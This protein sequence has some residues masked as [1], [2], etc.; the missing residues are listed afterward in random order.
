MALKLCKSCKKEVD[1]TAKTCPH[2]GVKDPGITGGQ[3]FIG[4]LIVV[5]L[6]AVIASSCTGEETDASPSSSTTL[7]APSPTSAPEVQ[8]TPAAKSNLGMT[9]EEFRQTYN[10]LIGQVDKSWRVAE[11]DVTQG[12]VNDTFTAKLGGAAG[13]VGTVDKA[14]KKLISVMVIAGGGEGK[15]NM[16]SIAVLM[17]TAH[18]L[19]QG[20][21]KQEISDAVSTLVTAAFNGMEQADTPLQSRT[22]GNRKLSATASS[23]TG[24]MF[25][26]SSTQ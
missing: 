22:V 19:T 7:T 8:A 26:V 15:D 9:P 1:H 2:C 17:S 3:I 6:V 5:A 16:Q 4:F 20:A 25:S 21:S 10:A 18:A 23:I 13:M 12:S 24:L 11:F 14:S